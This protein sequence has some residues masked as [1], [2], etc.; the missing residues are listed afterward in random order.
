MIFGLL[1]LANLAQKPL[2]F[3]KLPS[4]IYFA[5][6]IKIVKKKKVKKKPNQQKCSPKTSITRNENGNNLN[7]IKFN[8]SSHNL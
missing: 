8:K 5:I 3:I 1:S 7:Y 4:L 2:F 6:L